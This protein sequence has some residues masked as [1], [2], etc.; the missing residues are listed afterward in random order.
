MLENFPTAEEQI[1]DY[2]LKTWREHPE[3]II[4]ETGLVRP[5]AVECRTAGTPHADETQQPKIAKFPRAE[6]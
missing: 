4:E 1:R 3:W 5:E 2:L 6:S